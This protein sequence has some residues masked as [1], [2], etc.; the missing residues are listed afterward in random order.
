MMA[1]TAK[2]PPINIYPD[3]GA[4]TAFA[5][6]YLEDDPDRPGWQRLTTTQTDRVPRYDGDALALSEDTGMDAA[7]IMVLGTGAGAT[8]L[9]L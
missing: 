1:E 5:G 7:R 6:L 2:V 3:Q 8:G 9:I 4:R